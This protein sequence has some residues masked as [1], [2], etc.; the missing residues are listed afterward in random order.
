MMFVED[1]L[2]FDHEEAQAEVDSGLPQ[3]CECGELFQDCGGEIMATLEQVDSAIDALKDGG[4]RLN[5]QEHLNLE[6]ERARLWRERQ[7]L[8]PILR[9]PATLDTT[10]LTYW[11]RRANVLLGQPVTII[12]DGN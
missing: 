11:H 8:Q 5:S 10:D 9:A 4:G 12:S 2:D 7:A 3:L 1:Y 6:K